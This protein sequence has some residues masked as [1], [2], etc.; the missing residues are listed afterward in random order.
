M[1]SVPEKDRTNILSAQI[2]NRTNTM[3]IFGPTNKRNL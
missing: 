3:P 1:I 2:F